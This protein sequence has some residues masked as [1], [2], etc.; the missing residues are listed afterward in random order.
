MSAGDDGWEGSVG[1]GDS[2]KKTLGDNLEEFFFAA[3]TFDADGPDGASEFLVTLL[4]ADGNA[5]AEYYSDAGCIDAPLYSQCPSLS[6]GKF[7]ISCLNSDHPCPMRLEVYKTGSC[8]DEP[9]TDATST[10]DDTST[11]NRPEPNI[12]AG[13]EEAPAA[14]SASS[15]SSSDPSS[16][17]GASVPAAVTATCHQPSGGGD[18][19]MDIDLESGK[20][21]QQQ[22]MELLQ[23]DDINTWV[24]EHVKLPDVQ[25]C[26]MYNNEPPDESDNSA[27]G[28]AKGVVMWNQ[29]SDIQDQVQ[30][31]QARVYYAWPQHTALDFRKNAQSPAN[32]RDM[33]LS[34]GVSHYAK[35]GMDEKDDGADYYKSLAGHYGGCWL[36]ENRRCVSTST[37][38]NITQL[39]VPGRRADGKPD[40]SLG[41]EHAK[42]AVC[43]EQHLVMVGDCNNTI[44]QRKRGGGGIVLHDK[45]LHQMITDMVVESGT[46]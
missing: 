3:S 24:R 28:H 31:M 9:A 38:M 12:D 46:P 16:S 23:W 26:W 40:Y 2:K 35:S 22:F 19:I 43:K 29:D 17:G 14:G 21:D 4:D 5:L 20:F 42:M 30:H 34:A 7:V 25:G 33:Q 18:D 27:F 11:A 39:T 6:P 45:R 10:T 36:E 37:V 13:P 44:P 8:G 41:S 1:A 15:G 32:Y